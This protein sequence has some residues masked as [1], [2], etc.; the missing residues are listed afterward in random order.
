MDAVEFIKER[1][2]M[3]LLHKDGCFGCP[4]ESKKCG[5]FRN[6][7]AEEIVREVEGWSATHPHKTRQSVFLEQWPDADRDNKGVIALCPKYVNRG[8]TCQRDNTLF[9]M[10]DDCRRE[11][12]MQEVE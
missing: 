6:V 2:R 5:G 1:Q 9:K 4:L 3:C 11:F 12:W 7:N 10:C 8:V